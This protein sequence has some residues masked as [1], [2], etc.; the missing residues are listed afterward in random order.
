M[1]EA[2]RTSRLILAALSLIAPASASAQTPLGSVFT[3]QGKLESGGNPAQG[4]F[5]LR[6]TLYSLP[7]G[8][9]PLAG[10]VCSD[11]VAVTQGVFTT[12]IDFGAAAF[13]GDARWL[14]IGSDRV[15][16]TSVNR[17]NPAKVEEAIA[18]AFG[19]PPPEATAT[20][21]PSLGDAL[22]PKQIAAGTNPAKI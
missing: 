4:S 13:N 2:P 8:G 20:T 16:D 1:L 7:S 18:K 5:D 21:R 22:I 6:F 15:E 9:G 10:P 19:E 14:E 17:F 11:N 12:S 3:Y